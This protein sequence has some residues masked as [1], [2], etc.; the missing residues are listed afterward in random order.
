M[1]DSPLASVILPNYNHAPYLQ[2]RIESILQQTFSDFELILL[3]DCS[4]DNSREILQAYQHHP[5]VSHLVLNEHNSGSTFIQWE[6]GI[7][8]SRGTYIWIAESDD[9]ADPTFLE[10]TTGELEKDRNAVLAFTGSQLVDAGGR[11]MAL[12]WD[13]FPKNTPAVTTCSGRDYVWARMLYTNNVYNASMVVF[14]KSCYDRV[15]DTYRQLR[16][17]GDWLFWAEIGLQ[18]NMIRINRKLNYFRQHACRV[19]VSAEKK[20][21]SFIEGSSV[22]LSLSDKMNLSYYKRL[23]VSGHYRKR[24]LVEK[25]DDKAFCNRIIKEN[26]RLFIGGKGAVLVYA[27]YKLAVSIYKRL[28]KSTFPY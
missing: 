6:R 21:L 5:K 15:P 28:P 10:Q 11:A 24:L 2:Q 16:Y 26:S 20:G 9:F 4:T 3:D 13:R 22:I 7:Q 12:D 14:R 23:I 8:L 17:C 25:S 27:L 1:N 18:G 19:S